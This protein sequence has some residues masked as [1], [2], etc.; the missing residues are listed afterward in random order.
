MP[1][2][3]GGGLAGL[4]MRA[5]WGFPYPVPQLKGTYS[6]VV[7]MTLAQMNATGN[8]ILIGA[9]LPTS[10][11]QVVNFRVIPTGTFTGLTDLRISDRAASPVDVATFVQSVLSTAAVLVP[12]SAGVTLGTMAA[13]L[14]RGFGLQL[15]KTGGAAAGGTSV[16]CWIEYQVLP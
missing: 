5:P 1:N 12:G 14:T 3:V 4:E 11:I 16:R 8:A 10:K 6:E 7:D 15:R 2:V 13:P 9:N